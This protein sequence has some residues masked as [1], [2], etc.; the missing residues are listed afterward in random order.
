VRESSAKAEQERKL[1]YSRQECELQLQVDFFFLKGKRKKREESKL[2]YV[3]QE[4]DLLFA[5]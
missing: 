4:C 5:G 1:E 3:R 2:E